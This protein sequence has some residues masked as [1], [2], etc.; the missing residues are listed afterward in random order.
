MAIDLDT[1]EGKAL[2]NLAEL[3][4]ERR[5]GRLGRRRWSLEMAEGNSDLRPGLDLLAAYRRGDPPLSNVH[6]GWKPYIRAFIRTGRLNIADLL[7]S[8]TRNRMNLRGFRTAAGDDEFG[9]VKAGDIIRANG[10]KFVAR[11]VHVLLLS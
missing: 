11:E 10:L 4:H 3:L 6:T 1:K 9:D 8:A 5:T 2:K 7:I